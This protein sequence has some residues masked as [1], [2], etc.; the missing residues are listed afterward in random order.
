MA[1][2]KG[3]TAAGEEE[4]KAKLPPVPT[5]VAVAVKRPEAVK[6]VAT[7]AGNPVLAMKAIDTARAVPLAVA[8]AVKS[9][10]CV[11]VKVPIEIARLSAPP[12]K[13][14][15]ATV[16]APVELTIV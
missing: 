16:K 6:V 7:I 15:L 2:A 13:F 11:T 8:T 5:N 9:T 12:V 1:A 3:V 10:F 4:V 14:A